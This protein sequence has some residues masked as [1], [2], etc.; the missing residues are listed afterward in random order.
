MA[1]RKIVEVERLLERKTMENEIPKKPSGSP[2]KRKWIARSHVLPG[3]DNARGVQGPRCS[4]API[5]M[6]GQ[7]GLRTGATAERRIAVV[8]AGID[9][10]LVSDMILEAVEARFG[11]TAAPMPI[12]WPS[13][14][15]SPYLA[16]DTRSFAKG[17]GSCRWLS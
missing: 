17:L 10:D 1:P 4:P 8:N 15:G 5:S 9:G 11:A 2:E 16:A 6:R 13:D 3:D 14:N 7:I 12:Q